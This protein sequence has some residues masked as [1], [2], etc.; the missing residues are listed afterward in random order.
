MVRKAPLPWR[1]RAGVAWF[2]SFVSITLALELIVLAVEIGP[3]N[4]A[5]AATI[6]VAA[7]V[8]VGAG[9]AFWRL[10]ALRGNR[11]RLAAAL[12]L[13]AIVWASLGALTIAWLIE[14]FNR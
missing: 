8:G 2:V 11:P 6:A 5:V 10:A 3:F 7:A 9:I 13:V 14:A 4:P 12:L 1:L